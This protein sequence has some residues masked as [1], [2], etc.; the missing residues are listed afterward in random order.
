L[1]WQEGE[2]NSVRAMFLIFLAVNG[3]CFIVPGMHRS[4][5]I[6]IPL[7][8]LMDKINKQR[9]SLRI[10]HVGQLGIEREFS[11]QLALIATGF[12]SPEQ[13]LLKELRL[14]TDARG[15]IKA[16]HEKH[17]TNHPK[18]FAAGDCRR[19][20]SLVVWPINVGHAACEC[21]RFLMGA[22]QLP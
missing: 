16:E 18:I 15:N 13:Q 5:R 3:L 21:D 14:E 8:F 20:Q 17:R 2:T 6:Q 4:L 22:T 9:P 12:L 10:T 1:K 19:G 11:A 7:D